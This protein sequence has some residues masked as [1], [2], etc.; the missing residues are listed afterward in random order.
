MTVFDA[1]VGEALIEEASKKSGLLW[2]DGRALW[3]VW[4]DG[5][6]HVVG[7]GLEQPLTGLAEGAVVRVVARS[8]DKG[9]R[10]VAWQAQVGELAPGGEAWTAAVEELKG[11]RLNA[12]DGEGMTGRWA[13]ESRVL[14]LRAVRGPDERLPMGH[15]LLEELG[16][17]YPLLEELGDKSLAAVPVPSPNTTRRPIPAGLPKLLFRRRRTAD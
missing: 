15:P 1:L 11:K 8:K 5:A 17:G 9:G 2:V 7:D 13:R 4:H 14:S 10:I 6:V 12:P 16:M 3:H